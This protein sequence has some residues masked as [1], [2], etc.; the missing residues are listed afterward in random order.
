MR[1]A[2][3]SVARS[4]IASD[5]GPAFDQGLTGAWICQLLRRLIEQPRRVGGVFP[6][7]LFA[8]ILDLAAV[9]RAM[10]WAV[11]LRWGALGLITP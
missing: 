8:Q 2:S 5:T 4:M 1:S 9:R 10:L 7:Q 3:I 6:D 11:A